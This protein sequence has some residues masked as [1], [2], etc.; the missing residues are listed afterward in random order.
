MLQSFSIKQFYNLQKYLKKY[1]FANKYINNGGQQKT[2]S[3]IRERQHH[4]R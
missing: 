3:R 4:Q 2:R 1:I